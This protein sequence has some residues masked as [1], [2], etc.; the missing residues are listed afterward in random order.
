MKN[1]IKI[2]KAVFIIH[3]DHSVINAIQLICLEIKIA[4]LLIS[5]AWKLIQEEIVKDV[6]LDFFHIVPDAFIMILIV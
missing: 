1:A 3:Q 2:K 4:F 6:V 5:F